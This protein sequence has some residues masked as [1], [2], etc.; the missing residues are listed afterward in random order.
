MA[1]ATGTENVLVIFRGTA[2][3]VNYLSKNPRLFISD[4]LRKANVF[5]L[6][7]IDTS[8]DYGGTPIVLM[9]AGAM[10]L[11]SV[12]CENA[13]NSEIVKNN[14]T[15]FVIKNCD[16]NEI[17]KKMEKLLLSDKLRTKLGNNARIYIKKHFN[18][19]NQTKALIDLY[20]TIS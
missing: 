7:G 18:L 5:V 1:H 11:P 13:G 20:N 6:P 3:T 14:E 2:P 19:E 8:N 12:T 10:N 16:H 17:S 9:E 15:G 4:E